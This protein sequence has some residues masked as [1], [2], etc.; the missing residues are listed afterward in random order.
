MY[1]IPDTIRPLSGA[2]EAVMLAVWVSRPPITRQEI[3]SHLEH[4]TWADA[5]LLNF[6]YRL[7]EKGWV[8]SGKERNRNVYTPCVTRRA[9]GVWCMRERLGTLFGGDLAAAVYALTSE[10][11]SSRTQLESARRVLDEKLSE[12]EEYDLY[13][14]YG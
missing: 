13:D 8:K 5:T 3:A 6:L 10:S 7:E 9:Y 11:G 4:K 12:T 1:G 14:P 2:E